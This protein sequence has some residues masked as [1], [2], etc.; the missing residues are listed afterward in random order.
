MTLSL[1]M[2]IIFSLLPAMCWLGV[3]YRKDK[4]DP[5][6][7]SLL[8]VTFLWGI[9]SSLLLMGIQW[10]V[11]Q[12]SGITLIE[13]LAATNISDIG[14][15]FLLALLEEVTKGSILFFLLINKRKTINQYVDGIIYGVS[16]ALGFAFIE[17]ITYFLQVIHLVSRWDF[18]M[19]Y[20]FRT[21]GTMFAHTLFTGIVGYFIAY[22]ILD[23]HTHKLII[24][25]EKGVYFAL[26]D[27]ILEIIT[28]HTLFHHIL[29]HHP[30]EKGHFLFGIFCESLFLATV[31]H[32]IFNL[33]LSTNLYDKNLMFLTV[34]FLFLIASIVF[35]AFKDKSAVKIRQNV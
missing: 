4:K 23:I 15:T 10:L 14:I 11:V 16:I 9:G 12:K 25:K 29:S 8:F 18:I 35:K 19:T 28:M 7:I 30:S 21:L 5:E 22:G 32:G 24:K 31:L 1:W 33:L 6:P 2:I 26:K 34:P 27:F 20:L 13:K 17:N 3:Y